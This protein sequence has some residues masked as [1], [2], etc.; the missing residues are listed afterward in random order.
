MRGIA[1]RLG[2]MIAVLILVSFG[3]TALGSLVPGSAATLVLG[4]NASKA[5]IAQFN[6]TYGFDLPLF[7]RYWQWVVGVFHGN[8]GQSIEAHTSVASVILQALPVTLEIAILSMIVSLI[9]AVGLAMIAVVR[10]EGVIDRIITA[11]SSALYSIPV[12]IS[13]VVL[14]LIITV[15]WHLLPPEGWVPLNQGIG[16]NI[17]HAILPVVAVS[18][19]V[20]TLL[21]RVLRGDLVAVLESEYIASARASGLP[22]WY[23]LLRHAFR[24]AAVAL[25][26]VSG[27]V[28]GYLFGGSI[29]V[30]TFFVDPGLG[31]LVSQAEINK[32]IPVVQG[33]TIVVALAYVV[34]NLIVDG[35]QTVLDP[36]LRRRTSVRQDAADASGAAGPA[37]AMDPG[38]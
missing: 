27:L 23:V 35:L 30:E 2:Q 18:S 38:H 21:L 9:L 4:P 15:K 34:I 26:T 5:Q 11:I 24:P 8:L 32:D 13:A 20:T 14:V 22:E 1:G 6:H 31:F 25:I 19:T 28:F 16:Q 12:F 37:I 17:L 33:V 10:P 29:L 3:A 36:R 7:D